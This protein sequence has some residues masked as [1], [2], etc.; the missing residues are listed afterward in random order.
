MVPCEG[1]HTFAMK[2]PIDVLYL[3]KKR[4]VLKIRDNMKKSRISFC[5]TAHSVLELPAGMAAQTGTVVGDELE[6]EK[7][8]VEE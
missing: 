6:L 3:S 5:L 8:Q 2:F 1:V 7:R 4:K